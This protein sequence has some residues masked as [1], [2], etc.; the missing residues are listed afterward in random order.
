MLKIREYRKA[1]GLTMKQLGDRVGAL[2][3][4]ISFYERGMQQPDLEMIGKIADALN[5]SI[6]ELL[7][8]NQ[9]KIGRDE[10]LVFHEKM[11]NNPDY[12]VLFEAAGKAKPEHLRAAT[13][14]LESLKG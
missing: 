12:R 13:A 11:R 8:H 3:S 1:R 4:S 6:D 10:S 5:V 9:D 14:V 2:E 7:D